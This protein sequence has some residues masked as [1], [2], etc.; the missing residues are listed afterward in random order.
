MRD[1]RRP[2]LLRAAG[3]CGLDSVFPVRDVVQGCHWGSAMEQNSGYE[4]AGWISIARVALKRGR[5][6]GG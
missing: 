1:W 5:W 2:Q 6:G 3:G 4:I